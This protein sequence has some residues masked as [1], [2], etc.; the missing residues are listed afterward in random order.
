MNALLWHPC[1]HHVCVCLFVCQPD[2]PP[3]CLSG[4][5]PET[6]QVCH[7]YIEP[8]KNP[9]IDVSGPQWNSTIR[10]SR[11]SKPWKQMFFGLY[12]NHRFTEFKTLKMLEIRSGSFDH[13]EV[14]MW[15]PPPPPCDDHDPTDPFTTLEHNIPKLTAQNYLFS[16]SWNCEKAGRGILLSD[17]N[18][19]PSFDP[20]LSMM[21]T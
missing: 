13:T 11:G 3:T 10:R 9:W 17:F 15:P 1:I 8:Q 16:C 12:N 14:Y 18:I 19:F 2:P 6:D 21:W 5:P 20:S 4:F 7:T